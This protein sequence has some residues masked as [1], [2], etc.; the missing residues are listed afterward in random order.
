MKN[1]RTTRSKAS[2][3]RTASPRGLE[4]AVLLGLAEQLK[5]VGEARSL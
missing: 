5:R 2:P 1:R 4:R 3:K